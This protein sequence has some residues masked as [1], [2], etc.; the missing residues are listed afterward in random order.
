M[1]KIT[2][3]VLLDEGKRFCISL[4]GA[5]LVGVGVNMFVVPAGLYTGG[6]L[7][8]CQVV[9]TLLTDYA[10]LLSGDFDFAGILYYLMNIPIMLISWRVLDRRFVLRTLVGVTA[11]TLFFSILPTRGLL[12]DD[13]LTACLVGGVASGVGGGLMLRSGYTAGGMDLVALMISKKR[14]NLGVGR[15]GLTV[16]L[17]L[18]SL[19]LI[20]FNVQTAIYSLVNSAVASF[21]VD[22]VH[23][24]N[25]NMEV[26]VITKENPD[27]MVH[28]IMDKLS[29][30][31]T[32]I[33][34]NGGYTGMPCTVLYIVASKYE[35][36]RLRN[37]V[38]EHDPNAFVTV[39]EH[40]EVYGNYLKKL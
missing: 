10:H 13:T 38:R 2:S 40:T 19:C 17:L 33:A 16:N 30:G 5:F 3:G 14:R 27:E 7:G 6:L 35:I 25:I 34:A 24:Q 36:H 31:V 37:L 39:K 21:A 18:Y 26:L 8:L 12:G 23:I 28:D 22:K 29:R 4:L 9:R 15:V 1:K 11:L 20:L 32:Q